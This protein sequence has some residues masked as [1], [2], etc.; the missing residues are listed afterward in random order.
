MKKIT[1][2]DDFLYKYNNIMPYAVKKTAIKHE[3]DKISNLKSNKIAHRLLHIITFNRL[4][5]NVGLIINKG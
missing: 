1:F 3:I 5:N 2:F 4:E